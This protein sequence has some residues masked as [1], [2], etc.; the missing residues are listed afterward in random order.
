MSFA[1]GTKEQY[2]AIALLLGWAVS[3]GE[4]LSD[5]REMTL[6]SHGV[7]LNAYVKQVIRTLFGLSNV[8]LEEPA[9]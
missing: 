3:S 2:R 1:V 8:E 6:N 9:T 7:F 5:E 4:M